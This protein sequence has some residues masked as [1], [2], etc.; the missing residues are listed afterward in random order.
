MTVATASKIQVSGSS[1]PSHSLD[2]YSRMVEA[3]GDALTSLSWGK[4]DLLNLSNV[5]F[6]SV[7]LVMVVLEGYPEK[8]MSGFLFQ[9]IKKVLSFGG[10]EVE[11]SVIMVHPFV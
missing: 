5:S 1:L 3:L 8:D 7:A 11:T 9:S 2:R 4:Y 6:N 10:D